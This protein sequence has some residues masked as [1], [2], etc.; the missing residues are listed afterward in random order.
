MNKA[1]SKADNFYLTGDFNI[2][3]HNINDTG[4]DVLD[5]FCD[6]FNFK[7]LIKEK[8]CF[9]SSAGISIDVFL[10]NKPRSFQNTVVWETG[11]SDHH[12]TLTTFV[13]SHLVC[14]K[15]KRVFFKCYKLFKMLKMKIL[16]WKMMIQIKNIRTL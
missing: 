10:T 6:I 12:K 4:Y 9:A 13:R 15:P 16:K 14:L 5:R 8:T 11:L 7:N 1:L 3:C 2:D